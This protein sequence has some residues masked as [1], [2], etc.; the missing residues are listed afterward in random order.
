MTVV[1]NIESGKLLEV[2]DS[3]KQEEIIEVLKQQPL[4]IREQVE[5]VSG[6][7]L[8]LALSINT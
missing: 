5:E 6:E 8:S 1:C 2:I 3:H 4:E 7:H